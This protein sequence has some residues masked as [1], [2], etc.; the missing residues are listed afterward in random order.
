MPIEWDIAAEARCIQYCQH[1]GSADR[2]HGQARQ[3]PVNLGD[4]DSAFSSGAKIV[5][6]TYSTP[7]FPRAD[8]PGNATV[9]VATTGLTFGSVTRAPRRRASRPPGSPAFRKRLSH[10][11]S[12]SGFGHQW[13]RPQPNRRSTSPTRTAAL[14][15][16]A[17]TLKTSSAPRIRPWGARLRAALDTDGWPIALRSQDGDGR[18]SPGI[19]ASFDK[20]SLLRAQLP[21]LDPPRTSTFPWN[22]ARRRPTSQRFLSRGFMDELATRRQGPVSLSPRTDLAQPSHKADMIK[23]LDTAAEMSGWGS[24]CRKAWRG[25]SPSRSAGLRLAAMPP[26]VPSP[27]RLDQQA[28]RSASGARRRRSEEGFGFVNPLSVGKQIEGQITWF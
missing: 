10:V 17:W 23:A 21:L 4:C 24:R 1:A 20:G 18:E 15:S 22:A 6:A 2:D 16:P 25:P 14:P 7:I 19:I 26:S 8:G 5:E 12:G 11:P 3:R 28:R 9:L 13:Q 27:Y